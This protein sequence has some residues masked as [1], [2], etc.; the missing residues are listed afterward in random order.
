MVAQV[1]S[2]SDFFFFVGSWSTMHMQFAT[3]HIL[4]A[5]I[6]VYAGLELHRLS[7]LSRML[8]VCWHISVSYT[9]SFR[10]INQH[11]ILKSKPN[12]ISSHPCH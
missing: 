2:R 8:L 5:S 4:I 3:L 7:E 9:C 11:E 1:N 12:N 10:L 6:V